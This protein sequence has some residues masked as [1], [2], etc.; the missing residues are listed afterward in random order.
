MTPVPRAGGPDAESAKHVVVGGNARP[1]PLIVQRSLDDRE[2]APLGEV[3]RDGPS[4]TLPPAP[5]I[6]RDSKGDGV[7][8][9]RR[10]GSR[11]P[12]W[13]GVGVAVLVAL[14]LVSI[15]LQIT[16]LLVSAR[17]DAAPAPAPAPVPVAVAPLPLPDPKTGFVLVAGGEAYLDQIGKRVPIGTVPV[18]RYTLFVLPDGA[19]EFVDQGTVE[20]HADEHLLFRCSS[21]GCT[22]GG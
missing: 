12:A 21:D 9:S 7:R 13:L 11:F 1:A 16:A 15:G 17:Q 5:A 8:V 10:S 19:P 3:V 14:Q 6:A 20:V 4:R 18:G 22:K 2:A